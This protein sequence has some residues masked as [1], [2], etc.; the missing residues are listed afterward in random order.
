VELW[1]GAINLGFLY[2]FMA[3]GVFITFRIYDFPDITVDGSFTTGAATAAV[4]LV[5]GVNPFLALLAA[6]FAGAIAGSLTALIYTRFNV[7]GLLAGILVMTGLY[8]VN[9]HIMG[10]SNIPLLNQPSFIT[11]LEAINPGLPV[12]IWL[13]LSFFVVIALFW[14]IVSVFFRT[15][16]GVTMRATGNNSIMAS[17]SGVNVNMMKVFGISLANGLVGVSGSLVAQYQGFADIGMGIGSI[18]FGLAAVIIGE[19]VLRMRSIYA[20]ILSVI[21]GSVI[22]RLMVALALYVGLNPIDLKLIT[23]IFVLLILIAPRIVSS[24]GL[25]FGGLPDW[26]FRFIP[27]R[28]L[29]L[30]FCIAVLAVTVAIFGN[31]YIK[32]HAPVSSKMV[33]IGFVQITD[34]ALL[35]ITRDS[36][37]TE[38]KRLGYEEKNCII[39]LKD[40]NGE[41]PTVNTILDKFLLDRVDIV[42]PIST[43]CTQAAINKIKDRPVV[44]ATV[45]NP[46]IIGAGKSDTDHLANVTGVYGSAPMDKMMKIVTQILP[47]KLKVG[48][49]WDPAHVNSVFNVNQ[50][51]DV[52]SR[53][54]N[55]VSFLGATIT[56][57]SEVYQAAVSLVNRGIDVFVLSPDNIVY[58]AFESVVKAARIKKIP[59][60]ISDVERLKDGALAAYGYDYSISGIQ[61]AHLVDRILKGE[62]PADIPFERYRKLTFGLNLE[63]AKEIG[64]TI[65][66]NLLAEATITHGIRPIEKAKIPRIGIVQFAQEPNVELCKK[67]II[68]AL[69][70]N[71]FVDQKDIE[72]VY[73]NAN[74]DFPTI[75][76]II[77][78]L[79]RR[80]VDIIIPLST[81]CV[82]AAVQLARGKRDTTV[83][84]TYIFD[85]YRI[86]AATNPTDHLPNMT[87]VTCFPPIEKILDLIKEMFPE[88]KKI[89]V[90]WNSSEANSEAVVLKARVY[91]SRLGLQLVETTVSS[92]AEVLEASRSLVIKGAQVF[93]N[94][95][96]NTLNV[97]Y[98]SFAKVAVDNNIPLF[99]VDS[100][101]IEQDT[102]VA[103]GPDYYQ[104][105][106]DGGEVVARVLNQENQAEI[107]IYQTSKTLFLINL[108]T[109]RKAGF[110]VDEKLIK[111]ADKV[112]GQAMEKSKTKKRLALFLFSDN[113]LLKLIADGVMDEFKRSGILKQNN[114]TVD[115]KNAQNDFGTAQAVVQDI[116][117][118]KYDYIVT[119]STL[120]LQVTANVNRKIPHVFGGVTDPFRMGI[121]KDPYHHLPNI[122]GVA[123]LQPI[124]ATIS[125]MREL[126][127][128][129]RRIGIIW[130]PA[131]A[132]SEA[133]TFKARDTARK[134][135]FEL[136][137]ATVTSTSE[138]TDALKSLLNKKID[139]FLTSGD[140]TVIMALETIAEILRQH[141]IPYFTNDPSDI[142]RGAFISIGADY[143]QVGVETAKMA[144][145]VIS[146]EDPE[147]IPIKEFVPEKMYINLSLARLYGLDIPEE[148]L[149]KAARVGSSPFSVKKE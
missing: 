124:E 55:D 73:K 138:V 113:Y 2:A 33:R 18:I 5:A 144:Q 83:V 89:G 64:I 71:G 81:P 61:A 86:G 90:V 28:K 15:D 96:D 107:P 97:S 10:R 50:L 8:S 99:S 94:P 38:M 13:C 39:Y 42:V 117:R 87:G 53:Y 149:K 95:G 91:A 128:E 59:I 60:F 93:L 29:A 26:V 84:F 126:F 1:V 80:K 51:K 125:S 17:A 74:A 147:D 130:N 34:H 123:T 58:S 21:L 62:S 40:A 116:I 129:S 41:L 20:K 137:E 76:S 140:N 77:Q 141:K 69:V 70:D 19:S 49:I 85:P 9:L 66:P 127:P 98:G 57:S 143:Y 68:K 3:M 22:F 30:G 14:A 12:E 108:N 115:L 101:L 72:I 37:V 25:R 54:Y 122:T 6:F 120:A 82:Q 65:P 67:G 111:R 105:G 102:L 136:L 7:N 4:L 145:R 31:K 119:I 110:T 114:I 132:C 75:N 134:Y 106:Y 47:G 16:L 133:C 142:E 139:L 24:K 45:A 48:A 118:Q 146:G 35:N 63:M 56:N 32:S 148:F 88:R 100:E 23:A 135:N 78:D 43:P 27:R 112:I 46:F 103:L 121:A 52:I 131:E 44:F 92:P 11:Y 104:T 36:F 109:A 79:I